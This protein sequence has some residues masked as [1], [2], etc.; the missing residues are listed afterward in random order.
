[1][2]IITVTRQV[3]IVAVTRQVL[4]GPVQG[5]WV[6]SRRA[7]FS[8]GRHIEGELWPQQSELD[9]VIVPGKSGRHGHR[10]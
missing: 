7:A 1:V 4:I 2:L 10:H 9:A 8:V 3:L 5:C 6:S